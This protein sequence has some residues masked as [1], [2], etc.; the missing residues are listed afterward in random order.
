[1]LSENVNTTNFINMLNSVSLHFLSLLAITEMD[2][3]SA[4]AEYIIENG[5]ITGVV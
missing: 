1:M 5:R 4:P 3:T 2:G